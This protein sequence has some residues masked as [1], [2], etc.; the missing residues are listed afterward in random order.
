M[1]HKKYKPREVSSNISKTLGNT[2]LENS[3]DKA[4]NLANNRNLEAYIT[5]FLLNQMSYKASIKKYGD[6]A[7]LALFNELL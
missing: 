5:G 7:L 2:A 6:E 3:V 1:D 4:L